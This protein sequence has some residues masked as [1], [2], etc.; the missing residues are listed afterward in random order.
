MPGALAEQGSSQVQACGLGRKED[1][2]TLSL[3]ASTSTMEE[4]DYV[5]VY[6]VKLQYTCFPLGQVTRA[7]SR[8]NMFPPRPQC[9]NNQAL[10]SRPHPFPPP[11]PDQIHGQLSAGGQVRLGELKLVT[12]RGLD[13]RLRSGWLERACLDSVLHTLTR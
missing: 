6:L 9:H 7:Y 11:S 12:A 10:T 13:E 2:A 3:K 8:Q 5:A 1:N 4:P